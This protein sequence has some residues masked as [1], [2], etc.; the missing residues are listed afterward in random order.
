MTLAQD[1]TRAFNGDWRGNQG[2]IP[3]PGH[4]AKDRGTTVRDTGDG[5]VVFHSFNAGPDDWKQI[6]DQCRTK[7][8]LPQ[9]DRARP[10]HHRQP[11]KSYFEFQDADGVTVC[12]KV[13]TDKPDGSKFF[14]WQH[15]DG[16]GGW[17]S[18][19]GCDALP[20]R[21]PDLL[22]A[23][24]DAVI[25]VTEGERKADKLA[26]WGLVATSSKD[27]PADLSVFAGRTVAILPDNDDQGA[28]IAD[29]LL[30]AL[31]GI[32][33]RAF[34][35][36][37]PGLP[38]KGDI[39]DWKGTAEDFQALVNQSGKVARTAPVA[40]DN[41]L[42]FEWAG[43]VEPQ[44]V[45]FWLIK[46]LLPA[47]GLALLYGH[48]GS[49]KTFLALDFGFHVAM[50][51]DWQGK[52]VKQGLVVYVAAEGARGLRN[53]VAAFKMHHGIKPTDPFPLA[54]IPS[55]IDMQ[56]ADADTP[57]LA[58]TIRDACSVSGFD[59]A[60]VV[61]DTISKTFGG[62]KENTDDMVTYVANCGR[63]ASEFD[64]CV[65]PVHHR[66]KDAESQDPRGHS[67]LRGGSDTIIICEAG[68][69]KKA[70][71]MK[72][73]DGE[74]GD[75]YLFDLVPVE[76]GVDE[77]GEPVTSCYVQPAMVDL[78]PAPD[79]RDKA[80]AK[81][82]DGQR[83]AL[84]WLGKAIEHHGHAIPSTIPDHA[85]NRYM[86]AKVTPIDTWRDMFIS[87]SGTGA[88]Q[89]TSDE[90]GQDRDS[91]RDTL[92]RTF[93]RYKDRLQ[94]LGII[95][96][97]EGLAWIA[98]GSQSG[99]GQ[100]RDSHGTGKIPERDRRDTPSYKEG[101]PVPV[102]VSGNRNLSRVIFPAGDDDGL[103]ADG[104]VIGWKD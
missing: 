32:A 97:W 84:T 14:T 8:L 44:L 63:I 103:D 80:A 74:E 51:W 75:S 4:S 61:V 35:V 19:R 83:R 17:A 79:P 27:L 53:R 30:T 85:I 29:D 58:Q 95:G 71:V 1:I 25:Y 2:F 3:T 34:L 18:G 13:R 81:L 5:D 86:V 48:P 65:M 77:D 104:D 52:K 60:L 90:A 96:L 99:A 49:G 70:R 88:G 72:Q 42:E 78:N 37:L 16:K 38:P 41:A 36:D 59:P 22:A 54:I 45:G 9:R 101:C 62:G 47:Q 87:A 50:G 23:P 89:V 98:H 43:T 91:E 11:G 33:E 66:P 102:G 40:K 76:L 31:N 39:I 92:R 15:P 57:R 12:R 28:K 55:P 21:L 26:G 93:N 24:A 100:V 20:Y 69:P 68:K 82:T 7:G 10:L 6:K 56:A 46:K 73:K 64:C 94:A 67:S